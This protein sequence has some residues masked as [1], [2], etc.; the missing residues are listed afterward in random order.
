M[1]DYLNV[2]TKST[3]VIEE[4]AVHRISFLCATHPDFNEQ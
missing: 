4:Y 1:I 2:G 3:E